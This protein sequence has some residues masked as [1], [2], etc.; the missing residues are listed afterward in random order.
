[1]TQPFSQHVAGAMLC[2]L[3]IVCATVKADSDTSSV[4]QRTPDWE[5]AEIANK[6]DWEQTSASGPVGAPSSGSET[7]KEKEK[8]ERERKR[9]KHRNRAKSGNGDSEFIWAAE[10]RL[11]DEIVDNGVTTF[12]LECGDQVRPLSNC[13]RPSFWPRYSRCSMELFGCFPQACARC[14]DCTSFLW[15]YRQRFPN[16]LRGLP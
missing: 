14:S 3:V 11:W 8:D 10:G 13:F 1:M 16:Y 9:S 2:C 6:N 4:L 7:G 12:T 5:R 15:G